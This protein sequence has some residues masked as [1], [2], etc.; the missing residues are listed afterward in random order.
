MA[1]L[2]EVMVLGEP[3]HDRDESLPMMLLFSIELVAVVALVAILVWQSEVVGSCLLRL[4]VVLWG[5][6]AFGAIHTITEY[7]AMIIFSSWD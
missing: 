1:A 6:T 4:V 2:A 5:T 3:G 7:V